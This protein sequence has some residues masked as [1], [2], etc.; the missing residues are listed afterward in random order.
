VSDLP[1]PQQP[2]RTVAVFHAGLAALILIIAAVTGG[3]LL[4]SLA[5]AVGY[6]VAATAW[7][8]LRFRQ[9]ANASR[10]GD[11]AGSAGR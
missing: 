11:A 6:F 2:Y 9:R 5:V 3:E 1:P 8:W 7:S 4:K 10:S